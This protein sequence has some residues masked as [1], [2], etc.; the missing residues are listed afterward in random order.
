[1][2]FHKGH[3]DTFSGLLSL[4]VKYELVGVY[5]IPPSSKTLRRIYYIYMAAL[6]EIKNNILAMNIKIQ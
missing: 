3:T 1:M 6:L 5:H 4:Y 2:L